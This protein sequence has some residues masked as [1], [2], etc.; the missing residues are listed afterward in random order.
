MHR[1]DLAVRQLKGQ[2]IVILCRNCKI[3]HTLRIDAWEAGPENP[4]RS[5]FAAGLLACARGHAKAL[6]VHA[7][8]VV[9]DYV[10]LG[11]AECRTTYPFRLIEC[12]TRSVEAS[13]Q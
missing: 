11:C 5:Y 12:V 2:G 9:R 10:D 6:T 1:M 4:P 8:D 13:G 7:V 3:R